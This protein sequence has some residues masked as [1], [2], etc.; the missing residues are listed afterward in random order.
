MSVEAEPGLATTTEFIDVESLQKGD[1]INVW[2]DL[3]L[4]RVVSNE[5]RE[6][7]LAPRRRSR[8]AL[9][10]SEDVQKVFYLSPKRKVTRVSNP[11]IQIGSWV[12]NPGQIDNSSMLRYW[13]REDTLWHKVLWPVAKPF[14]YL[15][16]ELVDL[17]C[18]AYA[19]KLRAGFWGMLLVTIVTAVGLATGTA[20]ELSVAIGIVGAFIT[21][22][23][24]ERWRPKTRR[25]LAKGLSMRV[26]YKPY[27][28]EKWRYASLTLGLQGGVPTGKG[29]GQMWF[30]TEMSLHDRKHKFMRRAFANGIRGDETYTNTAIADAIRHRLDNASNRMIYAPTPKHDPH[31]DNLPDIWIAPSARYF[32]IDIA[33]QQSEKGGF[34]VRLKLHQ[35]RILADVLEVMDQGR[36]L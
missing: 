17:Q 29:P 20:P 19:L 8:L 32:T 26:R 1:L 27:G 2:Y 16:R 35:A 13:Q 12:R 25:K 11:A 23:I 3:P 28:P 10:D 14:A 4:V 33:D 24:W 15:W 18:R 9:A 31:S 34:S 6:L 7:L 36:G 22:R 30:S 5:S 21:E